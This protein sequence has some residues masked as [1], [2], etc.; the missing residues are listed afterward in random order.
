MILAIIDFSMPIFLRSTFAHAVREGARYAITYQTQG[1]LSQTDSIKQVVQYNA[2]GFLPGTEGLS[3]ITVKYYSP[4]TF[5]EVTGPTANRDGNIVEVAVRGYEWGWIAPLWRG[6]TPIT[7]NVASS[8]RLE[9]LPHG[10][11]RPLP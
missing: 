1:G 4:T 11:P 5:A 8:D 7:I 3:R 2:A 9:V 6:N 10:T